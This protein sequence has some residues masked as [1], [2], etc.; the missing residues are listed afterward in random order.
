MDNLKIPSRSV[1]KG[2]SSVFNPGLCVYIIWCVNGCRSLLLI[3][4]DNIAEM[5]PA[6][7][8]RFVKRFY[9]L[10]NQK[11]KLFPHLLSEPVKCSAMMFW[12]VNSKLLSPTLT[13]A[14]SVVFL[15]QPTSR[16]A[17]LSARLKQKWILSLWSSC[18]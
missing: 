5:V 1:L 11:H 7:I 9:F 6:E 8:E 14:S 10:F 4:S 3:V 16:E 18:L 12:H 15:P 13:H 17:P 2:N